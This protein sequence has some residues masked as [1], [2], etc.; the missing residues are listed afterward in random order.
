M[1]VRR[2]DEMHREDGGCF[3]ARRH[4]SFDRDRDAEQM[5]VVTVRLDDCRA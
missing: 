5:G 2:A 4:S 1:T 3:D